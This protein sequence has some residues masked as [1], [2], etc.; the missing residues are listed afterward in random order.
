MACD[1]RRSRSFGATT[2][3]VVGGTTVLV[4]ELLKN[5][6]IIAHTSSDTAWDKYVLTGEE[7]EDIGLFAEDLVAHVE[8]SNSIQDFKFKLVLERRLEGAW[9]EDDADVLPET[10]GNATYTIGTPYNT[11]SK[12][13]VRSRL[14]LYVRVPAASNAPARADLTLTVVVRLYKG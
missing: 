2:R 10:A 11:R 13:G 3:R 12:F 14:V 8:P 9:K 4:F 1:D 6:T 7:F 5:E